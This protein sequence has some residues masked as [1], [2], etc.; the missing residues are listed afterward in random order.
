MPDENYERIRRWRLELALQHG[1]F[2]HELDELE[3]HV[4]EDV[5]HVDVL[6]QGHALERALERLGD[7]RQIAKE[8]RKSRRWALVHSAIGTAIVTLFLFAMAVMGAINM[9]IFIDIPSAI[10]II[11]V[12]GGGLWITY[13]PGYVFRAIALGALRSPP[14]DLDEVVQAQGVLRR[15]RHLCWATGV[16]GT[17]IGVIQMLADLTNWTAFGAGLGVALLTTLYGALMGE[18]VFAS[19]LQTVQQRRDQI[20][21]AIA[22]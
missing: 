13:R 20:D 3:D 21:A 1:L 2:R 15:G 5:E 18:L 10:L 14:R 8:L 11:G 19:M 4:R 17:L 9:G 22:S 12:V 6:H 16:L 7:S